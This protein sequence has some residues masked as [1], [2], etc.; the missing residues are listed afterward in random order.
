MARPID[1]TTLNSLA[2]WLASQWLRQ[3]SSKS[4]TGAGVYILGPEY[5]LQELYKYD[6]KDEHAYLVG[7][8]RGNLGGDRLKDFDDAAAQKFSPRE[9]K[10]FHGLL[11]EKLAVD[12]N[13]EH[14]FGKIGRVVRGSR[15]VGVTS[16]EV[17]HP[18]SM[19]IRRLQNLP[20]TAR[21]THQK[22]VRGYWPIYAGEEEERAAGSGVADPIPPAPL[23][24]A[25]AD[26]TIGN[27]DAIAGLDAI[28]GR[29]D[30]GAGAATIDGRDGAKP[31]DVDTAITGTRLFACVMNDPAFTIPTADA[32][33]G[34]IGTA[35]AIADDT[36]ADATGTLGYCRVGSTTTPPTLIDDHM[37]LNAD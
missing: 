14:I 32:N 8:V 36:S 5:V 30:G 16:I 11:A 1:K 34:A 35:L 26:F 25:A 2:G 33:P 20:K 6:Y 24:M 31:A 19:Q 27:A 7:A 12:P 9:D 28:L 17:E 37:D 4:T 21:F 3:S 23:V 22:L 13:G 10:V 18:A 15:F 29:L